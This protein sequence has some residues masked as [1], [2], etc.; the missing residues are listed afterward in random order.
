[1]SKGKRWSIDSSPSQVEA[2]TNFVLP[3][4]LTKGSEHNFRATLR[5][6]LRVLVVPPGEG[7][8]AIF[9]G[10]ARKGADLE[11]LLFYNVGTAA[12]E[13]LSRGGVQLERDRRTADGRRY[14][15]NSGLSNGL[16][17]WERRG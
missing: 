15:Y 12:F 7:I 5:E 11:N 17:Y 16:R 10:E 13:S 8:T 6:S 4:E 1:M 3:F 14:V 2:R 9:R